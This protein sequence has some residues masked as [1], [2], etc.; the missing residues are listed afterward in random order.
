V[1]VLPIIGGKKF[2]QK[3]GSGLKSFEYLKHMINEI[4][5]VDVIH[6][7]GP[8]AVMFLALLMAPFYKSKK[9]WFKYANNWIDE[10][11]PFFW[12]LQK[13]LMRR[14]TFSVGTVNG[15]W[16]C[17]PSHIKSFYNP[18]IYEESINSFDIKLKSSLE[19]SLVLIFVGRIEKAKGVFIILDALKMLKKNI[20]DRI[21]MI[22]FIGD[23][24]DFAKVEEEIIKYN[25]PVSLL[26]RLEKNEVFKTLSKSHFLLLPTTASE[27][28]PKVIAEAWLNGV[29]PIVNPVS[30]IGQFVFDGVNGFHIK[31]D[32]L[33][34]SKLLTYLVNRLSNKEYCQM[35]EKAH[36]D[37]FNYTYVHYKNQIQKKIL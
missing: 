29:I 31:P 33:E 21:S 25:L 24:I 36:L 4:P 15:K 13:R 27:G 28:F 1:I 26:G 16:D 35:V 8:N 3:M 5:K 30:S 19:D 20:V 14:Y 17:E 12:G 23:G 34:L 2:L 18:C 6:V 11:P 32:A 37:L 7:R 9:W 10:K 22:Y